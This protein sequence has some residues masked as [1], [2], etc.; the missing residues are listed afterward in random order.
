MFPSKVATLYKK[1]SKL[2]KETI[3]YDKL[4]E[5]YNSGWPKDFWKISPGFLN[6]FQVFKITHIWS[7]FSSLRLKTVLNSI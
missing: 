6:F 4:F 1:K 2:Y 5:K 3:L 7:I